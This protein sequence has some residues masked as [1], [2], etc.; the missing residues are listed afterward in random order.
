[1][2]PPT[3]SSPRPSL[4]LKVYPCER[5]RRIRNRLHSKD[6]NPESEEF[7]KGHGLPKPNSNYT[8]AIVS[9]GRPNVLKTTYLSCRD[10]ALHVAKAYAHFLAFGLHQ[11]TSEPNFT[12]ELA[13][14]FWK[15]SISTS[16]TIFRPRKPGASLICP[17]S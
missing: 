13:I 8:H 14:R 6:A 9:L 5:G 3:V 17:L 10:A 11:R 7:Q 4:N 15:E 16:I 1:M 12:S 2:K